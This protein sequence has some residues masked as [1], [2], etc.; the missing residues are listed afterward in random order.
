MSKLEELME[1]ARE[2]PS[3]AV[4]NLLH[5]AREWKLRTPP[6]TVGQ[7]LT[8]EERAKQFHEWANQERPPAPSLPDELLRRKHLYE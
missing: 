6:R 7:S 5:L 4:E 2:L 1:A 8:P 3:E